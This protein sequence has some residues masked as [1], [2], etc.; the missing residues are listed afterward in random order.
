ML[1]PAADLPRQGLRIEP[2]TFLWILVAISALTLSTPAEIRETI[3]HLRVPDTDDAMRLVEVRDLIAGQGWFDNVQVR[4][5]PP[6]GVAS[7]WSRLV[8]APLAG[9]ILMLTPLAGRSLAEGL[10]AAFWPPLLLALYGLV[11]YRGVRPLFGSL[12][13]ILSV[14]VALHTFGLTVQFRAGRVDHH[15]VQLVAMLGLAVC[16]IRGGLGAGLVGGAL[17]AFSLAV[18]LETLPYIALGALYLA[19]D[20]ILHGRRALPAFLGFGLGLGLLAPPL[21]AA[22]TAPALWTATA[23]DALSPP[24]LWLAAGGLAAALACAAL[25]R[26]LGTVAARLG[27]AALM[28]AGIVAGF[29]ALFPACLGGPFPGM[30]PLVREH[31]LYTVNEMSSLWKFVAKGQW[32]ALVFYPVLLI[33]A[34]L[35]AWRTVSAAAGER[36][37]W[38]VAALFLWPGLILGCF[39]FR[40]TYIASGLVPLVAGAA[41]AQGLR[42][43]ESLAARPA[44]RAG[45]VLLCL[46]LVS[47]VWTMPVYLG[48]FLAPEAS[49]APPADGALRCHADAAV[50][51]LAALPPG[52]VLAPIFIG[53]SILLRT[54]HA[55]VAAPYHRAIPGLTAAIEGLGGTEADLRRHVDRFGVRYVATCPAR[56]A[57][58]L[59]PETAFATRLTRGEI[60]VPWLEPVAL[61]DSALKVWRVR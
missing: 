56:P 21:F 10:V 36:R 54:P 51:P 44:A 26:R 15:N 12:A 40:G 31:W 58:D 20:W 4:F 2:R 39:Q 49:D 18:G 5:M 57:D 16:L 9:L 34:C 17:A 41:I 43:W 19:G 33:A 23:C 22:Q 35:A 42:G 60:T 59:Q 50:T 1:S 8:D 14:L 52:T 32:E 29:A 46:G 53:P 30:T 11:L 24:W 25:D 48:A 37:A 3:D 28:G 7:H 55:V 13:A 61:P 47:A 6:T 45:T 27:L 38:L